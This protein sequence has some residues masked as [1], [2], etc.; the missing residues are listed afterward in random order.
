ML[1]PRERAGGTP[2]LRN[3]F[4]D[5]FSSKSFF[6][7]FDARSPPHDSGHG[8]VDE[9]RVVERIAPPQIKAIYIRLETRIFRDHAQIF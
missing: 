7:A 8:S 9:P 5:A 1:V 4:P 2:A 6:F 3:R